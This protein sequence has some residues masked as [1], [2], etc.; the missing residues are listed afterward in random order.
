M[1]LF[2]WERAEFVNNHFHGVLFLVRSDLTQ[3]CFVS[4]ENICSSLGCLG[5]SQFT[6]AGAE[7]SGELLIELCPSCFASSP[8]NLNIL[9]VTA[10]NFNVK[11]KLVKLKG[12]NRNMKDQ[13][14]DETGSAHF[15]SYQ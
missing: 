7:V 3:A 11:F 4:L 6:V 10:E 15:R 9:L 12:E 13:S 8:H 14:K 5:C 1:F 2:R